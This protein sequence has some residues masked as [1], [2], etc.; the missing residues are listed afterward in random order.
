MGGDGGGGRVGGGG[1]GGGHPVR[2]ELAFPLVI[3]LGIFLAIGHLGFRI[4]STL[5]SSRLCD[6]DLPSL[7]QR[8]D[9]QGPPLPLPTGGRCTGSTRGDV[10]EGRSGQ[11]GGGGGDR[12]QLRVPLS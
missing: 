11:C 3:F 5:Q 10:A 4:V 9:H 6:S 1:G 2:Q 8:V 7:S 12:E